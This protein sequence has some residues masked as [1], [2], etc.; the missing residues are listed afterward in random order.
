MPFRRARIHPGTALTAA[1][2]VVA[3]GTS[4]LPAL[5]APTAD[6]P[7]AVSVWG[8]GGTKAQMPEVKV[9]SNSPVPA[10]AEAPVPDEVA[11]WRAAQ[12]NRAR[13]GAGAARSSASVLMYVPEGQGSVPWHQ[14]SDFRVTDSL[15]ARVNYSNGNLMLAATD[16]DVAGVGQKL[17]LARTYNSLDAPWGKVSQRWWQEYERYAQVFD[18][19][20]V[21]YDASGAAVRFTEESDGTFTTPKGYSKDLKKNADGTYT[22]TDRKSGSKDTYDAGGTLTKVTDRNHGVITITQH[23][24]GVE[25]KGFKVTETR[26]GRWVDLLKTDA[27][28]WQAKDHTGRTAVYDLNPAGDV[29]KTTDT[30]GKATQFGYDS[31]RRLTKITTPEGRV[32]VFTYDDRN[33]VTSMLRATALNGSGHTGPTWTY[34]YSASSPSAAGTTKVTDPEQH[35]TTYKHDSDGQVSDVTDALDHNRTRTFDVNRNVDTASDAMGVGGSGANVTT[36]GWDGRNNPTSAK[37]PTGATSTATGYQ[38]IAGADLP[39][40]MTTA[41]N[42]KTNYTYDTAGNTKSVAVEG[43]GGGNQSFDYNPATPTCQGFEGQRCRATTKMTSTKSVSTTFTYDAQG[44]L[45]TVTAPA[46]LGTTTYSYD[47]LGRT[48]MVKDARGV[49]TLYEYD[50]RDRV[51][52]VDSSNYAT[53]TYSY[54][55][56]GNLKQRSDGT[57]VITYDFD[58]LS[59]ETVRTLQ[60]GSQ[61]VLAYTPA[62]NV[63]TYQDPAGVTDYTW[64]EVNKLK[65]LKDPKGK[66]TS[67]EY[68]KNDFREKTTYPGSTVQTVTPDKSGRPE[69]IKATSPKGTLVD[70]AYSYLNGTKDGGKIR[71]STDAVSG[72]KTSY[73]YDSAGRFSYA[74]EEKGT[75]LNSSWQYCYDLAGNLTSQGVDP[76]CPRGTTYTINDAQ[77]VTAKNGSTANWSY[78]KIGNETAGASTTEG[79]RTGEK[80]SDYS[81]MTSVTV[82]GKTY[83]GQYGST[84][85]SERIKLGDTF[86]HNGPI[87]LAGTSTAGVD[88]GFNREP[89]GTLNSMTRGG[90]NYYYLTD[91]LGSVVAMADETGAKVNSYGY[92]PRGVSRSTTSETVPQPYRFTGG[93]QDPTGL[94]HFAARYYDP[95]I[96]RFTSPDPSGQEENPYLYAEGDPVNRIDPTGLFS[97]SGVADALGP[98]GDVAT[99][100]VHLAQGD[101][102]ALWGDVAGVVVGG[103]AGALCGAAV[104]A[105]AGPT[106][107][108]SLGAAAGCYAISWSAGQIASN[109]VSG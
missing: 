94:Y 20:V 64:N 9:G 55:G 28:Q 82:A 99:G 78:D 106:L 102:K 32:T 29:A 8:P 95:N 17:R 68:D 84:D 93:Y 81:Q 47:G 15:V 11:A 42:E 92:S 107:G 21:V 58:P 33:R 39:G 89:G 79:T 26:S 24:E 76:G 13:A 62:G 87:G 96:G 38:T 98:I 2:V 53:V 34:T 41:D 7:S 49:T 31:S 56:D 100:S 48:T 69:K 23:D 59:R 67:Y 74:K 63:D 14:I 1:L 16:F 71:T 25:H 108:G 22:L 97:L 19:E 104:A 18:S 73:S 6:D 50:N 30:E 44:N 86:F 109:A 101:T 45:K 54:D 46:P 91:A 52:K 90:K 40:S 37:L 80:W 57:G 103:A 88:T 70:L 66:I 105:S 60:D 61:T 10:E 12:K 35:S 75:T 77:Q 27:S 3:L 4:A 65:A 5:A 51:T 43:T 36:Y 72:Y 83:A 85:Q